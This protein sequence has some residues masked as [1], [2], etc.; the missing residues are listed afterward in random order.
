MTVTAHWPVSAAAN[1][2]MALDEDGR[3]LSVACRRPAM[4]LLFDT[5]AGRQIGSFD[6]VGDADDMFYDSKRRRLYVIGGE[7][8]VDVFQ[9]RDA[10]RFDRLGRVATAP[11]AR[12][13]LFVPDDGRLFVAV[14][15]RGAQRAEIR[16]YDARD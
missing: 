9:R 15:R 4:V 8:F 14:P 3:R 2:P 12:T 11:G 6:T 1:Y 10:D 13:G 5:A 7:G 16:I